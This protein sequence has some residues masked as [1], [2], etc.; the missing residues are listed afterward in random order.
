MKRFNLALVLIIIGAAVLRLVASSV[1]PPSPYWEEVALGYDAYS[2]L[3][4]G[5]DHHGHPWPIVAL[6]SF[7]DWK[8]SGYVYA[9]IP[10][11]AIFGL[12]TWAVRLPSVLAGVAMVGGVAL[13]S[14]RLFVHPTTAGRQQSRWRAL[15]IALLCAMS[16]W[17]L[18]LS[19]SAW[20]TNLAT[21]LTIWGM[22]ALLQA[23]RAKNAN[24]IWLALCAS[25]CTVFAAYTYHATR[26]STPL[27]I[28]ATFAF[29]W[30]ESQLPIH[31][32]LI[33]QR[34]I[35]LTTS[36]VIGVGLLPLL[37]ALVSGSSVGHRLA[38][39]SIFADSSII[40][41]SNRL[42]ET[43]H[44]SWWSRI[45]YHRH[46]LY[47]QRMVQNAVS[48]LSPGFLFTTGD[49][50]IRHATGFGGQ[51]YAVEALLLLLGVIYLWREHRSA[52]IFIFCWI[53]LALLPASITVATPHALRAALVLPALLLIAGYGVVAGWTAMHRTHKVLRGLITVSLIAL[54]CLQNLAF[55][56]HYTTVYPVVSARE[57]QFG[58]QQV[59]EQ[60]AKVQQQHPD[61]PIYFTREQGRPAMYYWFFTQTDP[62]LVQAADQ[63]APKDQGEFLQFDNIQFVRGAHEVSAAPSILVSSV[64]FQNEVVGSHGQWSIREL[65][66]VPMPDPSQPAAWHIYQ[67]SAP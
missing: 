60:L 64:A 45:V 56:L 46:V 14:L 51:L 33:K 26:V 20:E 11:I 31:A 27:L 1:T 16:P 37:T 34:V 42:R 13:L 66:V 65:A 54:Y 28:A 24:R 67:I 6:E 53:V 62:R 30:I 52:T 50:N 21:S 9:A 7:G 3:K 48:H 59:V 2:L 4:T 36:L 61:L 44:Y 39:T 18:I 12:T 15:V 43:F 63:H 17:A 38:E 41:Q 5:K 49:T 57:W 55:W 35:V 58:Y 40:E 32:W 25:L 22:V 19:R 10:S 47:A 29:A 23:F 8:P